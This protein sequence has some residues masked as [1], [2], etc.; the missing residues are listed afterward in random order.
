MSKE[1]ALKIMTII[2]GLLVISR[3]LPKEQSK[4]T[5][6]EDQPSVPAVRE[7]PSEGMGNYTLHEM[8]ST[9]L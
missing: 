8:Y 4:C 9:Y 5:A 1:I 3:G 7:W 6:S 2:Y